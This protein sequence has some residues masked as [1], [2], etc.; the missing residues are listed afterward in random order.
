M[1]AKA[2]LGLATAYR[3]MDTMRRLAPQMYEVSASLF[4]AVGARAERIHALREAADLYKKLGQTDH[5]IKMMEKFDNDSLAHDQTPA[6]KEKIMEFK[7]PKL[8]AANAKKAAK[9]RYDRERKAAGKAP[10]W[11]GR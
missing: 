2:M 1:H 4:D 5:A 10:G 8:A 7:D 6:F 11:F 3:E 9:E